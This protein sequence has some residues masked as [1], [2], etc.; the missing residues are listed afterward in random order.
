MAENNKH[1]TAI[2]IMGVD[3]QVI[4]DDDP[5]RVSMIAS[6]VDKL[7]KETK[8]SAPYMTNMS[9]AVLSALNLS[10]ELYRLKD[11]YEAVKDKSADFEIVDEYK[12]RLNDALDEIESNG[13][14]QRILFS[15]IERLELENQE[16]NENLEEYKQ[17]FN[18]LR[19]D[20]EMN[21]RSLT[22]MQ[23]KLL[24]NQIELV[25]A[26]KSLLDIND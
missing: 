9:A 26:R 23:N 15:K 8:K 11:E 20:Y 22:E 2:N 25:K 7:I 12:R 10:E 16:L 19:A 6:F 1:K 17:K 13:N 21:K 14:K 24:D 4:T 3:Y 5:K 18:S